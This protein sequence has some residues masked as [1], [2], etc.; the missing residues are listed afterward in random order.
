MLRAWR[1]MTG[2]TAE[3]I[4]ARMREAGLGYVTGSLVDQWTAERDRI[5]STDDFVLAL[6]A[7]VGREGLAVLA[8]LPL[9][10]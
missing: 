6:L 2:L 5:A 8:G 10:G 7:I 1:G 9:K 4:A 3:E